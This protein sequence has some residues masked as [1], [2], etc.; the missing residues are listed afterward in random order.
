MQLF[1][2][3]L[4]S[5]IMQLLLILIVPILW[6]CF[7]ARKKKI[8][9]LDW[10]G[11]KKIKNIK[12][13]EFYKSIVICFI[14]FE[15]VN[16]FTTFIFKDVENATSRFYG[17]GMSGIIPAII[18]SFLQT[19]LTEEILFRGF[20]LKRVSNKFGFLVGN[21]VQ[22]ILFGL[23]HGAMFFS[24]TTMFNTIIIIILTGS[25]A[26][27]L[28]YINEKKA[29]GSIIPSWIMHGLANILSSIASLFKLI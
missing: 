9:F 18:Y 12:M 4:I 14:G 5:S 7:T 25:V 21:I 8:K 22:S 6:W 15:I 27:V 16:I 17:L 20:I 29:N 13:I 28:G 2:S 3:L 1:L 23:L 10:I 19:S 11:I 24:L 26:F